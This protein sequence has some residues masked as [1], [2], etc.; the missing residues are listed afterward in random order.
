[1]GGGEFTNFNEVL[2]V[3][4]E[5]C[6]AV[7]G[8]AHRDDLTHPDNA[9]NQ[10]VAYHL[11]KGR[12][13]YNQLTR[14]FNEY[15]YK[16]GTNVLAPQ[17]NVYSV[18]VWDYF[19]T[20]GDHRSLLKIVQVPDGDHQVYLNRVSRYSTSNFATMEV[21][22]PGIEVKAENPGNDNNALNGFYHP[23]D[24]IL[25][26]DADTRSALGSERI[27]FDLVTMLPELTT[28]NRR[29]QGYRGFENG[30][31][32]NI[33]NETSDTQIYYLLAP[34]GSNWRD[35][36]GDE[37][38]FCGIYDFVVKLPPV[39]K[40]GL[41]E[42]RMG[43]AMNPSRSMTQIYFGDDVNRL[44]PAGLPYDMRQSA[45]NNPSIP[46]VADSG[47]DLIDREND[48]NLRNQGYMKGPN[49]FTAT[50]GTG[51]QPARTFGGDWPC[52]RRI[53][54]TQ[55]MEPHKTYYMRFKTVLEKRDSQLFLDF[56]ELVPSEVYNGP[57]PEDIW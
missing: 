17:K 45:N 18:D 29:G 20:L 13:S 47:N 16:Y 50:N 1:M 40:S 48:K 2:A 43:V 42:I 33:L 55:Q 53:I 6:E 28:N 57:D 4:R 8:A 41:Y 44:V 25:L 5:K 56:F 36:Q 11:M 15:G 46:W 51:D 52:M 31:F 54:T 27:R 3:V 49:Y 23:I 12:Y 21:K 30:Y 24:G 35:Y 26:C 39:P 38:L 9:V 10:F 34:S 19:E 7:Y 32:E 22:C 37:F 14:H